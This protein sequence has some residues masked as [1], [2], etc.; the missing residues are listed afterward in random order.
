MSVFAK[1]VLGPTKAQEN[2]ELPLVR[3][4]RFSKCS[5]LD[6]YC[7]INVPWI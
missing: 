2:M 5:A 4:E 3:K 7:L 6:I 1:F